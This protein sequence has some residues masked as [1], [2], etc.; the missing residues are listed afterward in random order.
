MLTPRDLVGQR[1]ETVRRSNLS[2]IVRELHLRGPRSRSE[3]V[4]RT[5]LTRS[6]IRGL[7]G[8]LAAAGLVEETPN[9]PDGAPGR[10]SPLVHPNPD[11]AVV[12][13]LEVNVDSLAA[14]VV[15]FGGRVHILRRVDR[16]RAHL[17]LDKIVADLVALAAPLLHRVDRDALG[18]VGV[19]VAGIVRRSDGLV[20]MGPNLGWRDEPLGLRVAAALD[21]DVPVHV[22][23][24]SDLGGLAEHRRGAAVGFASVVY[25]MGEVGVGGNVIV[26]DMPL[27][28]ASGYAAEVGHMSVNPDGAPCGCGS[29]GCWETEVGEGALL[30][31][32]GRDPEGGRAAIDALIDDAVAGDAQARAGLDHVARWLGIG[33]ATLVNV[34]D[35]ERIVLGGIFERIHPLIGDALDRELDARA[36]PASREL[37][38]VVPGA[39]G[40]DGPLIGAAEHAFEPM[41]ADPAVRLE[42]IRRRPLRASA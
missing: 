10:P 37:V 20:R 16:P 39:L 33:L 30:L 18:A 31:R 14:A 2:A 36:L 3:L 22:A 28:G 34:F 42:A 19:A 23:N 15:G 27:V 38:R 41:L 13:A 5:G 8:E 11:G 40:V 26:E 7:I 21:L 35:P 4:A 24:E 6:A 12:L 29:V 1:S 9:A 17:A 32:A 25:V